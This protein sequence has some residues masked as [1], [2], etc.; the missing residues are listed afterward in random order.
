MEKNKKTQIRNSKKNQE[1]LEGRKKRS[2]TII[3]WVTVEW[4]RGK[5]VGKK[6][7][8]LLQKKQENAERGENEWGKVNEKG[9][10]ERDLRK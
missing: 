9:K 2:E 5:W 3:L 6:V 8:F 1:S 7:I 10:K 4:D